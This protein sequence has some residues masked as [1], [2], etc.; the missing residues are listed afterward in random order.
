[1][2]EKGYQSAG[3]PSWSSLVDE[4]GET[5]PELQWPKSIEVYDRMRSEDAQVTSVMRAVKSPIQSA[6][7][8]ID[9]AG[10]RSEVV[11]LV[12]K[13]L[14]LDV[15][16]SEPEA[17]VRT[18]DKGRFSWT[19]HLRLA[20][21]ELDHG[22]SYFEQVYLP[23]GDRL[24]LK[25]LAWRPARTISDIEVARDGGLVAIKQAGTF[26]PRTGGE[27]RIPVDRLVAYVNE[28]EGG[29]W[30]GRSL[31]R[32]AYKNW[33]LKDRELRAQAITV[34]R[35]GMGMPV[36]TGAPAPD[37]LQGAEREKWEQSEKTAGLQLAKGL[38]AGENAG[39]YIPA[40]GKLELKGVDGRLP[41]VDKPIRYQD[42]QIA[43]AVLAHFLNLGTET[44]S[45]AL[46]STF[47]DFFVNSLNAVARQIADVTQ[48]HVVE[49]LV[50][51]NWGEEEPAPRLV[52]EVI[53]A[54]HPAT[55]QALKDLV[56]AGIITP[57][58]AL[59]SHVRENYGLPSQAPPD[60]AETEAAAAVLA[61]AGFSPERSKADRRT[62]AAIARRALDK[63]RGRGRQEEE[64]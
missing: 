26:G 21:L 12:A 61:E 14:G 37:A 33:L 24:M 44:G 53:G 30:L 38:K 17:P 52:F 51:A 29:N 46:G 7:W 47:A 50:D 28:R 27:V 2:T 57:D 13:S 62:V 42:E 6:K 1:M 15:K 20:L 10:A 8:S 9:P 54:E 43:R 56:D 4:T 23:V 32:P 36:V 55:A 58:D 35:N 34:E 31:L 40:G 22:H 59:E 25:K 60:D 3:V 48:Q 11:E 19:E 49:D 64:T 5:N 45:W 16:G 63:I 41:D 18:R 39:A